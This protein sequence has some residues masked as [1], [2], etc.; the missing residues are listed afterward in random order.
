[1]VAISRI[2]HLGDIVACEPVAKHVRGLYPKAYII[3]CVRKPYREIVQSNPHIDKTIVVS[4]L[5]EWIYLKKTGLFKETVDLHF[6]GLTC[7][8]CKVPLIKT[9]GDKS[10]TF[11][12][13]YNLGNL[14]DVFVKSAG[15]AVPGRQPEIYISERVIKAV[16]NYCLPKE[17]AVIHC[18]SNERN[19]D[20]QEVKWREL[21]N[22]IIKRFNVQIIE[23]GLKPVIQNINSPLYRNF[24]GKIP[25]LEAAE[26]IRRA[27]IFIG[28]DSGFAHIANAVKTYGIILLGE[29]NNFKHYMPYSGAYANGE[30]AKLIYA[31]G[32]VGNISVE[33]VYA[34][35]YD[36]F[37]AIGA[38]DKKAQFPEL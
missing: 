29:Y 24:C 35:V 9:A 16:D 8:V 23:I 11:C 18:L 22:S 5:T 3:W 27:K 10:I 2:E 12:N 4:C 38:A 31:D 19:R 25:L 37:E 14:I 20:W 6:E 30:T 34:A 28:I 36:R 15:L 33:S 13:Y 17:I 26:V 32:P 7:P 1:M 21:V